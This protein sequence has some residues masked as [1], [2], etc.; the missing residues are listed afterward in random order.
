MHTTNMAAAMK[1]IFQH[2]K[3]R[4]IVSERYT[5]YWQGADWIVRMLKAWLA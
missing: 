2:R 3:V 5:R 1:A 4:H